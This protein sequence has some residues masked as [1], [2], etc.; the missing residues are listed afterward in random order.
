MAMTMKQA[1]LI[2][3]LL[4]IGLTNNAQTIH[5]ITFFDTKDKDL[6]EGLDSTHKFFYNRFVY[7]I[8]SALAE[9]G[10]KSNPYDYYGYNV[11][12]ENCKRAVENLTAEEDDIIVFYYDGH[13][14]RP[15]SYKDD[16]KK[17]PFPQMCL[18]ADLRDEKKF[19]PLEWVHN[20]LKSK[21][22]RLVIT[23]GSCCNSACELV[24]VKDEPFF[25]ANY[26]TA[27]LPQKQTEAIQKMFL[28]HKGDIIATTASPNQYGW[29]GI[30]FGKYC[31]LYGGGLV[32]E[33][34]N[35]TNRGQYDLKTFFNNVT[36]IVTE[37]GYK[38]FAET[39]YGSVRCIVNPV[40]WTSVTKISPKNPIQPKPD[41]DLDIDGGKNNALD[42]LFV[43]LTNNNIELSAKT[44]M[45]KQFQKKC[46]SNAVVKT[47]AQDIDFV[48]DKEDVNTFCD[49]IST[50]DLLLKVVPVDVKISGNKITEIRVK[51]YYKL[52]K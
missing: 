24:S 38:N 7:T 15:E 41:Y 50:S 48:V 30:F 20:T 32:K 36:R 8:N 43:Y 12:P 22:A 40:V 11:S 45:S 29:V 28:E 46:A 9:K 4:C 13:G 5:W 17:H 19:I 35:Y 23:I 39:E 6:G 31:S 14:V 42:G 49:R 21:G 3:A 51:E 27:S 33:F 47:L 10:Y 26:K 25:T 18:G 44:V 37:E 52:K 16:P 2:F 34:N 1:V